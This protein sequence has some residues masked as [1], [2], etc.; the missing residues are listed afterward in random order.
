LVLVELEEWIVTF[1]LM[2]PVSRIVLIS[3]VLDCPMTV[4]V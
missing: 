2:V 3:L 4:S 1:R